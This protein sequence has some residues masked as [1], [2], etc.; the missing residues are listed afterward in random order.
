[1]EEQKMSGP[2]DQQKPS[3]DSDDPLCKK[4]KPVCE[5]GIAESSLESPWTEFLSSTLD[6]VQRDR[7]LGIPDLETP[8]PSTS[9]GSQSLRSGTSS[10]QPSE[11]FALSSDSN[12]ESNIDLLSNLPIISNSVYEAITEWLQHHKVLDEA[13]IK[14][15][16][17]TSMRQAMD[18][19]QR[20]RQL[21]IPDLE[22]PMPSTSAGS[23]SLRSDGAKIEV[24][25]P[26]CM[27]QA[28]ECFSD[29]TPVQTKIPFNGPTGLRVYCPKR[30]IDCFRLIA[31]DILFERVIAEINKCWEDSMSN[32]TERQPINFQSVTREEFEKFIALIFQMGHVPAPEINWYWENRTNYY[33]RRFATIMPIDRFKD[34]L[35]VFHV[36]YS[37]ECENADDS[38]GQ[39]KQP[40]DI[41]HN[42][43]KNIYYPQ[44]ELT[45]KK[46]AISLQGRYYQEF[47]NVGACK[48][49]LKIYMLTE[50]NGLVL[51]VHKVVR[52]YKDKVNKLSLEEIA[53]KLLSDFEEKGHAI[54]LN[55]I[56]TSYSLVKNLLKKKIY[57][58]GILNQYSIGI[59]PVIVNTT[60]MKG[61]FTHQT[62]EGI[63]VMKYNMWDEGK[64][65][66]I[67][68]ISSEYSGIIKEITV[69]RKTRKEPEIYLNYDSVMNDLRC[70]DEFSVHYL[71][72]FRMN[73]IN[74]A[75]KFSI[76][77]FHIIMYNSYVL[78]NH[79][80][81]EDMN[82]SQFRQSVI[83]ALLRID[84]NI[85]P[86]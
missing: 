49:G 72:N 27:Q 69:R 68:M 64:K 32:T 13:K 65:N 80:Y 47:S 81:K 55:E 58:T 70:S 16:D 5:S 9:A 30:P 78:F 33:I 83:Y 21:G 12:E 76:H 4:E 20:D 67:F 86:S 41:F 82:I 19:V 74:W 2:S 39:V 14:L 40:L 11:H 50:V 37:D 31:N 17:P 53:Y 25:D 51:K 48:F 43:M 84:N 45:I 54:Y 59:P 44:K 63:C 42:N 34:I 60:L 18:V 61:M 75:A 52:L 35:N 10:H 62:S 57:V 6:V 23:Q 3:A 77:L 56:F 38:S 8:M 79:F 1:M 24:A 36:F 15:A 7:R 22:T 29:E 28:M 71:R 66:A 85:D 73:V 26:P 46:N